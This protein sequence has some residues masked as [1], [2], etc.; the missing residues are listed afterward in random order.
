MAQPLR[1]ALGTLHRMNAQPAEFDVA[2]V[3][4]TVAAAPPEG[5]RASRFS[6]AGKTLVEMVLGTVRPDLAL[7]ENGLRPTSGGLSCPLV[8][9]DGRDDASVP[10]QLLP[11]WESTTTAAFRSA[12]VSG[13]PFPDRPGTRQLTDAIGSAIEFARADLIRL[14]GE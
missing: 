10:W 3:D 13:G 1:G 9:V 11:E 8:A 14:R 6:E 4:L 12:V 2:W 7:V 5:V